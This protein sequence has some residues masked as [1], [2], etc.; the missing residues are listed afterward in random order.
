MA[1]IQAPSPP[2]RRLRLGFHFPSRFTFPPINIPYSIVGGSIAKI[3]SIIDYRLNVGASRILIIEE[4]T[5]LL[6]DTPIPDNFHSSAMS[7]TEPQPP[8]SLP[9]ILVSAL[10]HAETHTT[11]DRSRI[12]SDN[13]GPFFSRLF[14]L[15]RKRGTARW[16]E[17]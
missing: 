2:L 6:P 16:S 4:E 15:S 14:S 3:F 1:A 8:L 9:I 13:R 10:S 12:V 7:L 5:S 11:D 17:H